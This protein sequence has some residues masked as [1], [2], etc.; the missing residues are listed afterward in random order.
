MIA[1]DKFVPYY[2]WFSL[3]LANVRRATPVILGKQPSAALCAPA[4]S[5]LPRPNPKS[6]ASM[7]LGRLGYDE[8]W[9]NIVSVIALVV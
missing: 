9:Y 4:W 8:K 1:H 7:L 6:L 2:T 3:Y 5:K